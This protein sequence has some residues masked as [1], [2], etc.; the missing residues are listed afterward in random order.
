M[1][2]KIK[3]FFQEVSVEL[4]KVSWPTRQQTVS[5]TGVVITVA[6][7][8]AFFLGIVD[9]ILARIVGAIMR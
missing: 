2:E 9:A 8:V 1:L 7:I 6:F 5:A 3:V 4:K